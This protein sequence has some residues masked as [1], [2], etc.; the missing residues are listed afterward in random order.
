MDIE[1]ATNRLAGAARSLEAASQLFG[2][3]MGRKY[4]QRIAILRSVDNFDQLYGLRPLRLCSLIDRMYLPRRRIL[5]VVENFGK[6]SG[7]RVLRP[8]RLR[9]TWFGQ[10]AMDIAGNSRL[11]IE[12]IEEERVRILGVEDHPGN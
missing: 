11:I 8:G 12:R 6:I 7:I 9:G 4:I 5:R 2:R 3:L 10:Y 1:F